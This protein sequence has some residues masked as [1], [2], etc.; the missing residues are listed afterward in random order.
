M[1]ALSKPRYDQFC[2]PVAAGMSG[3]EVLRQAAGGGTTAANGACRLQ[4]RP[5]ST[6]LARNVPDAVPACFG[7][8]ERHRLRAIGTRVVSA[9]ASERGLAQINTERSVA[10]RRAALARRPQASKPSGAA[11][12]RRSEIRRKPR[13]GCGVRAMGMKKEERA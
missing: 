10:D 4:Q 13:Q 11:R 3:A 6:T 5:L 12:Q 9:S 8:A 1:P 7:G 2:Q